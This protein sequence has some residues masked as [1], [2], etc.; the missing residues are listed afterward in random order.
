MKKY[1]I[2]LFSDTNTDP[3]PAMRR[4]M[5]DAEVGNEVAGE[6]PTVNQLL[7]KVC[8]LLGKEAAMFLPSGTMCNGIAFRV[9][10]QR[11]GDLIILDRT[12][13]PLTKSAGLIAGLVQAQPYVIDGVRGIF[14]AQQIESI[15][16]APSGYNLAR[17]R[18]VSIEQTTNLG[19]GA[20]WPLKTIEG[21]CQLAH[22]YE[23]KTH[24][25]G[26]RL[27]H[28][29]AETKIP[30]ADYARHFDSVW[31]DFSKC[32]GAPMGS[33]LAGTQAFI[34][35][36]WYY[37]FQQGGGLH[38]AG[39]LAAGCLYGLKHHLQELPELHAH[40]KQLATLLSQLSFLDLNLEEVQTNIIIFEVRHR[41]LSALDFEQ[42]LHEQGIRVLALDQRRIRLITHLEISISEI[43]VIFTA[44]RTIGEEPLTMGAA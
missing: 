22:Y 2:D 16:A 34:D 20:I 15:I 27:L 19:G 39:I 40:T 31:I 7:E 42:R 6:D 13:H 30:A 26:A 17:P 32:L 11:P 24:M 10:C 23:V 25:D 8:A 9:L 1:R 21:V 28:A 4:A 33:V 36:A 18:I 12:A 38:Q 43:E 14:S 3:V 37:K 44:I 35:E 29:V 41:Y 5:C